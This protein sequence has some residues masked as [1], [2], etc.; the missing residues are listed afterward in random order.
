MF[1]FIQTV[2]K[3]PGWKLPDCLELN[4]KHIKPNEILQ[5]WKLPGHSELILKLP[6]N[7]RAVKCKIARNKYK[8]QM[9]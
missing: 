2:G 4:Q 5:F 8:N 3:L 1:V 9:E 6:G 7:C